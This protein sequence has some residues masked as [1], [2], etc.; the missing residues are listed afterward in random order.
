MSS[1]GI[2][3]RELRNLWLQ[4]SEIL[5]SCIVTGVNCIK[6]RHRRLEIIP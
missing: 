5:C 2:S 3:T 4:D 6:R 1:E